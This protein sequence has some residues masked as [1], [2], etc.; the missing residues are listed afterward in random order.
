MPLGI[1]GGAALGYVV[2][3]TA[4]AAILGA[5]V[6]GAAATY[7]GMGPGGQQQQVTRQTAQEQAITFGEQ[8]QYEKQLAALMADP[9]SVTK[10][11]GYAF[12]FGQGALAT[13]RGF[14]GGGGAR[15]A[16]LTT[17]G[18]NYAMNTYNQQ[19]QMLSAIAGITAPSSP[20]QLG[21]VAAGSA[22]Q[23]TSQLNNTLTQIGIMSALA[24]GGTT[25]GGGYT[26]IGGGDGWSGFGGAMTGFMG[27]GSE[28]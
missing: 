19:V 5:T 15:D 7:M 26:G 14:P 10:T 23:S 1:I 8:Q 3:G 16:A 28:V 21:G 11:P 24:K 13:Q 17:Y 6:G 12:N 2:G 22:A 18:Q 20:G 27:A 25:G 9:S 4:T